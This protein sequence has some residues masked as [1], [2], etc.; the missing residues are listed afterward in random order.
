[1]ATRLLARMQTWTCIGCGVE[2]SRPT[3]RGM[4]PKRCK[5]CQS[6]RFRPCP[7]CGEIFWLNPGVYCSPECGGRRV[8]SKDLVGPVPRFRPLPKPVPVRKSTTIWVAGRCQRCDTA[9]VTYDPQTRYC[10]DRCRGYDAKDRRRAVKAAAFVETV[11]RSRI[12]ERD[13]WRCQ[14]CGKR[15]KRKG[16]VPDPKAPTI[17]H[18]LPLDQHGTHEPWNVQCAH[19]GCN[20]IKNTGL[21]LGKPE[22]LT[23]CG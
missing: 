20:V 10:S 13:R 11:Y 21:Y 18:I 6:K 17:D 14:L 1:M 8:Y 5:A 15:V 23:L 9:F 16:V 3:V 2:C 4:P 22:Q 7:T 19:Y 12:F